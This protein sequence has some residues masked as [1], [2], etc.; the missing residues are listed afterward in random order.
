MGLSCDGP[1]MAHHLLFNLM[2]HLLGIVRRHCRPPRR[3]LRPHC[4]LVG[5]SLADSGVGFMRVRTS[6]THPEYALYGMYGMCSILY[7]MY[8]M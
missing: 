1:P 3:A 7:S 4:K 2:S 8:N 6:S 5:L